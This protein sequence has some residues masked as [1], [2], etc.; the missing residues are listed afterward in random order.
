M[1]K[2]FVNDYSLFGLESGNIH[3]IGGIGHR[4]LHSG[5]F[6]LKWECS[7][8]RRHITGLSARYPKRRKINGQG[9]IS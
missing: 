4:L 1:I 3:T 7:S 9:K 5:L 6:R 8:N 2:K